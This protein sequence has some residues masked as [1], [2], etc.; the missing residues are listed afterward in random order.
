MIIRI[1]DKIILKTKREG[2]LGNNCADGQDDKACGCGS[3]PQPYLHMPLH[4]SLSKVKIYTQ[5][6]ISRNRKIRHFLVKSN[7]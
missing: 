7:N 2:V 3:I 4:L 5:L 1:Y 6:Y